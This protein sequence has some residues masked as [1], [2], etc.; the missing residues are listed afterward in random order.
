MTTFSRRAMLLTSVALAA[1][2]GVPAAAGNKT[3]LCT[4]QN[5]SAPAIKMPR[6]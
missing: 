1:T 6:I 5:T 3:T 2:R 4:H